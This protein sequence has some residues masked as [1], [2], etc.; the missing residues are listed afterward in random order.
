MKIIR[1]S[2]FIKLKN[3]ILGY[4]YSISRIALLQQKS[5]TLKEQIIYMER[6]V[7]ES[8]E[9]NKE[10]FKKLMDITEYME[11]K[12][13][14]FDEEKIKFFSERLVEREKY[15]TELQKHNRLLW[16]ENKKIEN[17]IILNNIPLTEIIPEVQPLVIVEDHAKI[18]S[19]FTTYDTEVIHII[20]TL[21]VK[22]VSIEEIATN[23]SVRKNKVKNFIKEVLNSGNR[24]SNK[25]GQQLKIIK[26]LEG[27]E[28]K[29]ML[30]FAEIPTAKE[31]EEIDM[32][33]L[34]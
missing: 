22:P 24:I 1:K 32:D 21:L 28:I 8:T 6:I 15:I 16:V 2:F 20:L 3:S 29:F 34:D 26:Y 23:A 18:A 17:F 25:F 11:K 12:I 27:E 30:L 7:E 14:E 13:P 31:A 10:T 9:K 19:S 5:I 4:L 33:I